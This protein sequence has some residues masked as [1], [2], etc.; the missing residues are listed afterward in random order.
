MGVRVNRVF[1]SLGS[2]ID[3]ER[4]LPAAVALLREWTNVRAVSPVYETAP[5]GLRQQASF[6]NAAVLIETPL[7]AVEVKDELIGRLERTLKRERTADKNAPRTIDADIALFNDD[8]LDYT[9]SDGRARH[10]PDP[11]LLRFAHAIVPLADLAPQQVHP[12]TGQPL[13][14]LARTL[15]AAEEGGAGA[16][17]RR[18]DIL[19]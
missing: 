13:A 16:L 5:M 4:N 15:L 8:V 19:L 18:D 6:L 10:V 11:D 3:K 2:N 7:D 12:E 17:L 1:L 14:D 9:P